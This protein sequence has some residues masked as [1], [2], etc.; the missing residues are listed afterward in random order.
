[1]SSLL[2]LYSSYF[3]LRYHGRTKRSVELW[4]F[5]HS[6][7]LNLIVH[8]QCLLRHCNEQFL[9]GF[10][11]SHKAGATQRGCIDKDHGKVSRI[12]GKPASS[13]DSDIGNDHR[14]SDGDSERNSN[15]SPGQSPWLERQG[16][17]VDQIQRLLAWYFKVIFVHH[18]QGIG[19]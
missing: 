16:S 13:L 2:T 14:D 1:M 7:G 3:L 8:G 9:P 10:F 6:P 19:N 5:S 15:R 11:L 4:R 18:L 17:C 12:N